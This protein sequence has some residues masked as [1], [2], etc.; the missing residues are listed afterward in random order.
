[1]NCQQQESNNEYV[2]F[3]ITHILENA[4]RV[5][6]NIVPDEF[7]MRHEISLRN[8]L[9]PT[10]KLR[11]KSILAFVIQKESLKTKLQINL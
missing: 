11:G 4:L 2:T 6:L 9:Q 5:M 1:M 10:K 7:D 8:W 3:Y